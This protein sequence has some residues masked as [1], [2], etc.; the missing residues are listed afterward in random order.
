MAAGAQPF[1]LVERNLRHAM[2]FYARGRTAGEVRLAPGLELVNCGLNYAVFNSALL[3]SPVPGTDGGL[4]KR[5]GEAARYFR[6]HGVGW[7]CWACH[8]LLESEVLMDMRRTAYSVGLEPVLTAPGMY[9]DR[10]EEPWRPVPKLE[11]R[12]VVDPASRA[13]FA[14]LVSVIFELPFPMTMNMY[15]ADRAW[16]GEYLGFLGYL[17]NRAIT[18]AMVSVSEGVCGFYSV[19]TVLGF[20]RRGYAEALLREIHRRL[21]ERLSIDACVLQSSTAG[22]KLYEQMGFREVTKFSVFRSNG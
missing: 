11:V 22:R 13:A 3:A 8:D 10:W 20:R 14:H 17:G 21:Q 5:L 12:Q 6:S 9:S 4:G 18:L 1:E 16:S 15:G 19:G 2:A 7:S